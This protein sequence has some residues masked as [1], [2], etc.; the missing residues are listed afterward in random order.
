MTL[1]KVAER[2]GVAIDTAR[3]VL[4]EDPSVR[5]Y[6]RKRVEKAAE[7]LDYHPNLIARA[8]RDKNL[9]II[10]ISVPTLGELYFGDLAARISK[11]LVAARMEPALCFTHDHLLTMCRSFSTSGSI[12]LSSA[13]LASIRR[14]S[15]WQKVVSF[16]SSL[17]AM[18]SVCNIQIDFDSVYTHLTETVL[19]RNMSRIAIISRHYHRS[20]EKGWPVQKIPSVLETLDSRGLEPAGPGHRH[21]FTSSAEMCLW[22]DDNPG[23]IDAIFCENDLEAARAIGE[24]AARGLRTPDDILV[25]GCDANCIIA[26]MWT[27]KLDSDYMAEEAVSL[28]IK[29][30]NGETPEGN[31]VYVPTLIDESGNVIPV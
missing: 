18:P 12:V 5:H 23:A 19:S 28:L 14:L 25:V 30:I 10:P 27:I 11:C 24:L 31:P 7:E 15:K 4:R 21:V 17:P 29:L 3:K 20:I 13:D 9:P 1:K 6:L 22:L 26:G 8:L 16:N 2:A